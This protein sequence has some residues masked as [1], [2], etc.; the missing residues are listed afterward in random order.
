MTDEPD[1]SDMTTPTALQPAIGRFEMVDLRSFWKDEAHTFTRWLSLRENLSLLPQELGIEMVLQQTEASV[2]R[3]AVDIFAEDPLAKKRVVVKNQLE[4]ADHSYLGQLLTY[5]A[6]LE[7]EYIVWVVR[8]ARDEHRQPVEWLNEHI[9]DRINIFLV[10]IERRKSWQS[11]T[12]P[13]LQVIARP[14]DWTKAVRGATAAATGELTQMKARQLEI[15]TELREYVAKR[16]PP[17]RPRKP[18][19]QQ[20]LDVAIGWSDC[21]VSLT[22]HL[23]G[24]QVTASLYIPDDK[25]LYQTLDAD[26]ANV[27]QRLGL[28]PREWMPLPDLKASRI[29]VVHDFV[30]DANGRKQA[31]D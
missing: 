17:V 11:A 3:V 12:E 8:E 18:L 31:F 6:G 10:Q 29:K 2:G 28:D 21:F 1:P 16:I 4:A 23:A 30:D 5:A 20:Y 13:K 24:Q 14:N 27:E 15:W 22:L 7:A 25:A 26:K 9:D 19:A